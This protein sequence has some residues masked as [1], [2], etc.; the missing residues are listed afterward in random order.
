MSNAAKKVR[1]SVA[2]EAG[3]H[4]IILHI[5]HGGERFKGE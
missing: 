4:V 5:E 2:M 1:T 3:Q